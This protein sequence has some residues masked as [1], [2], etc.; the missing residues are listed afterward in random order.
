MHK[1]WNRKALSS[2][3]YHRNSGNRI[4]M[5]W[6]HCQASFKILKP[7]W[8]YD[9]VSLPQ[10]SHYIITCKPVLIH[11]QP[12][13][14]ILKPTWNYDNLSLP[15]NIMALPGQNMTLKV[16]PQKPCA[17]QETFSSSN[18]MLPTQSHVAKFV[19]KTINVSWWCSLIQKITN[20]LG[21]KH[22]T[23]TV[24]YTYQHVFC[25]FRKTVSKFRE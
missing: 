8:N 25:I 12:S 2:M 11:C 17:F 24:Q 9:N 3:I 1:S 6:I 20:A 23:K 14:K 22:F 7:T 4:A 5:V 16:H 10:N 18:T 19:K 13:F 21:V 15:Q